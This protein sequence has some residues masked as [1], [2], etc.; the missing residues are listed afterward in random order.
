MEVELTGDQED[1]GLDG[2]QTG[3]SASTALGSL[4]QAVDGF[5][6]AVGL[7]RL[8]P[9]LTGDNDA[10]AAFDGYKRGFEIP[11]AK[12]HEKSDAI[13]RGSA[14]QAHSVNMGVAKYEAQE[15]EKAFL[16]FQA[17]LQAHDMLKANSQQSVLEDPEQC[18]YQLYITAISA[19]QA[20]RNA[21][22]MKYYTDLYSKG[23]AKA[24]VYE[25]LF[26]VKLESGDEASATKILEEGRA[27]YPDDSGLWF[28]EINFYLKKGRLD[29]RRLPAVRG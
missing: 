23:S 25:G 12:K 9:G 14:V 6:K 18:D 17:S 4:E 27:K 11:T 22:A 24:A 7:P 15:Y 8:S 3:E 2:G 21:D 29:A 20:K 28:S 5:E 10:L 13:K 19:R 1:D 26:A 16:S